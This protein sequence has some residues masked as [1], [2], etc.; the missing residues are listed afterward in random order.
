M[1]TISQYISLSD[2]V[3]GPL[4]RMAQY[5]SAAVQRMENIGRAAMGIESKAQGINASA[6]A[7]DRV[8]MAAASAA[9]HVETIAPSAA[10]SASA[11]Q[12]AS[13]QMSDALN[14][15]SRAGSPIKMALPNPSSVVGKMGGAAPP[16]RTSIQVAGLDRAS[17]SLGK[18]SSAASGAVERIEA[19]VP[20]AAAA[21]GAIGSLGSGAAGVFSSLK[22]SLI[23][24]GSMF[25]GIFAIGS[26]TSMMTRA[27]DA[28]AAQGQ[29]DLKLMVIMRQRMGANSEMVSSI[30][31]LIAAQQGLGVISRTVQTAG[32]QQLA[33]FLTQKSSL[34]AL[35]PAMNNLAAQ[36]HGSKAT[37]EDMVSIS[38]MMG[39]ALQGN[40]GA[41][42][43]CGISFNSAQ[44]QVLKFGTEAQRAAVMAEVITQNVGNMNEEMGKTSG[45]QA[46]Q[47]MN[48]V[49]DVLIRV[50]KSIKGAF[51]QL[52]ISS[53]DIQIGAIETIGW[54]FA[55][56]IN[57]LASFS[58]M[59]TD[60]YNAVKPLA[61]EIPQF[62][63]DN[64]EILE[65]ILAGVA[66]AMI[67]YAIATTF[68]VV[69]T[70]ALGVVSTVAEGMGMLCTAVQ[71]V[72]EGESVMAVVSQLAGG[73]AAAMWL[74][75][76]LPVALVIAAIYAIVAVVNHFAGTTISAT[77]I[78]FAVFM[79]LFT[80][81][82][83]MIKFSA[84]AFIAFANFLGS[85]FQNP[86]G[87]IYNLFVDIW[88]GVVGYVRQAVQNVID[89]IM[90]IPGIDKV[91]GGPI[92][93]PD[94][95][96]S[97]MTIANAA[98]HINPF[99][100]GNSTTNAK[101]GYDFGANLPEKLG[102][103]LPDMPGNPGGGK[104]PPPGPGLPEALKEGSGPAKDTAGHTGRMA[105]KMDDVDEDLKYL[106]EVAEQDAINRYTTAEVKID[107]GGVSN[108][109]SSD[110]DLDGMIDRMGEGL[111][112]VIAR[113]FC[114]CLAPDICQKLLTCFAA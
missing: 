41:L 58:R 9:A 72:A 52:K 17:M 54:A 51:D 63:S 113:R 46:V 99:E 25:A 112:D 26:L 21:R 67:A 105:D 19:L 16:I 84:N 94:M 27:K 45:G 1:S 68:A 114:P 3:S 97:R 29:A 15:V 92:T 85:V 35:I 100:Y 66:A 40:V 42:T 8:S 56:V 18:I 96:M 104:E 78:I 88:N 22:A 82:V 38:N 71:A 107:M 109:V 55:G 28:A 30:Q 34:E 75:F 60:A 33:T 7:V 10:S 106:R 12:R 39:R 81:L 74:E 6:A 23:S 87:A 86:L 110:V 93:L 83:N 61:Q 49:N 2:G 111:L 73:S 32:A 69:S 76:I 57:T 36:Q 11:V 80:N 44:E 31:N 98:W 101:Q 47:K 65:P 62:F 91:L 5:A 102:G 89:L 103:M 53:G 95:T 13:N 24:M 90:T 108:N 70:A 50:G 48:Q 14:R 59:A 37:A 20:G 43:R 77:G 64:W 4:Q 79:W